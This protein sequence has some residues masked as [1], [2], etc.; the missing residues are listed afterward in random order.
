MSALTQTG[1]QTYAID[2]THS[3]VGFIVRHLG[4]SK[5]RGSFEQVEGIVRFDGSDLLTLQTEATI[6]A[7]SITTN[8]PKR[9]AHLRSADFFETDTFP[10]LT[11]RSLAVQEVDGK[12]FTLTGELTMHGVTKTVELE[13]EYLGQA[14]DPWGGTRVSFEART[15]VNRK[16]YG[17]NWNVALEAGGLL[18]SESVEIILEIQAVLQQEG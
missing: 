9:D 12:G 6:Q 2:A 10:T 15:K 5:V 18:V 1:L 17:L 11:F 7:A 14:R 4:F 3:R 13:G 16:D 8:E